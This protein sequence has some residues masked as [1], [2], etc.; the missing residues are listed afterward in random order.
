MTIRHLRVFSEVCAC[1]SVTAAASRLYI[2]QP[3]ASAAIAELEARYGVR[4]FDRIGRRLYLTQA[5]KRFL[6]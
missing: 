5:G 6:G 1:G 4:L 2:T 3:A